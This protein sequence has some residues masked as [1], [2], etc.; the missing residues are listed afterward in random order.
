V[1][2]HASKFKSCL[3]KS[4][5]YNLF[6]HPSRGS[7]TWPLIQCSLLANY[8]NLYKIMFSPWFSMFIMISLSS[9]VMPTPFFFLKRFHNL[10]KTKGHQMDTSLLHWFIFCFVWCKCNIFV[11][12]WSC[13]TFG[14]LLVM[15]ARDL[16]YT[17]RVVVK[18]FIS[19]IY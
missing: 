7:H 15:M 12:L 18:G 6:T 17:L 16:L 14:W 19:C 3:M 11:P 5:P 2:S 13:G 8:P 4:C 1:F 10:K 9:D